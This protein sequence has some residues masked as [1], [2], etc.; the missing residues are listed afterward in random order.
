MISDFPDNI[1]VQKEI[2]YHL[3]KIYYGIAL[4]KLGLETFHDAFSDKMYV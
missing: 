2:R 3:V 4:K 1:Y